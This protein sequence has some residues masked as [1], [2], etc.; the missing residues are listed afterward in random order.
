MQ[1]R[2]PNGKYIPVA[3]GLLPDKTAHTYT[4]FMGILA[5]ATPG[6]FVGKLLVLFCLSKNPWHV[7]FKCVQKFDYLILTFPGGK[8]LMVSCDF[9]M[10]IHAAISVTIPHTKVKCCII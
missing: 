7:F 9:E 1:A 8:P 2:V 6:M 3:Y 4:K 10:A 5:K